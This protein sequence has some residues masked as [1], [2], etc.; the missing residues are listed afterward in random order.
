MS[1]QKYWSKMYILHI[2]KRTVYEEKYTYY[3]SKKGKKLY[4]TVPL[5]IL[6]SMW[7][8]AESPKYI[9]IG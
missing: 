6:Y 9:M 5:F 3:E 4:V 8:H 2:L 1:S 7:V